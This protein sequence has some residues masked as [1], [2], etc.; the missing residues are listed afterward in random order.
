M[1]PVKSRETQLNNW[2]MANNIIICT[3][4]LSN[5]L[6]LHLNIRFEQHNGFDS[7]LRK[8]EQGKGFKIH[9]FTVWYYIFLKF[10]TNIYLKK[11]KQSSRST[12]FNGPLS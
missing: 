1:F 9:D 10:M 6:E 7:T 2:N 5:W 12:Q 4:K 8:E 11:E 3:F